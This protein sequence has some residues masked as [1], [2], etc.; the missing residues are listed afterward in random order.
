[1]IN[2]VINYL[3]AT[4][5]PQSIEE[6]MVGIK[7]EQHKYD[8]KLAKL[9]NQVIDKLEKE[10]YLLSKKREESRLDGLPYVSGA[11]TYYLNYDGE[12]IKFSYTIN[13][14]LIFFKEP[15]NLLNPIIGFLSG[16][17]ISNLKLILSYLHII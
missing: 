5:Q 15:K 17:I 10:G 16:V 3:K 11:I 13:K 1:M 8:N 7:G 4:T 12:Q 14:F 6:I 2:E 9:V